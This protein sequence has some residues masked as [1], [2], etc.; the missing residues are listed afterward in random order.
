M[1]R[2]CIEGDLE[3]D[4]ATCAKEVDVLVRHQ[5]G[6]TCEDG[7]AGREVENGRSEAIGVHLRIA[8]DAG[9]DARGLLLERVARGMDEVTA[10]IHESAAAALNLVADIRRIDIEVAE[11]A[12]D[13]A[14]FPDAMLLEQF[15]EAKPLGMT[16]DHERFTNFDS[17]AGANGEQRFGF[18]NSEAEGLL[19]KNMLAGF[20]SLDGQGNVELIGQRIVNGVDLGVGEEFLVGA[21]GTGDA[22]R[23]CCFLSLHEIAGSDANDA[24]V[25]APL[26]GGND[27]LETDIG[28]AEDSPA[29]FLRCL[30]IEAGL[31][32]RLRLR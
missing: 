13:R 18:R 2:R 1:V 9:N 8:V 3:L 14:D 15:A 10:D 19:A 22:K 16:V 17:G 5:L 24:G 27:F 21:V 29:E 30:S 28:G 32:C 25:L 4:A 7:L 23:G 26:H 31:C 12:N 6:A 20:R 11:D